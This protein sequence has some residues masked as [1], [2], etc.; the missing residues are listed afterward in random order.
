[1]KKLII[2]LITGTTLMGAAQAQGPY[3][4]AGVHAADRANTF[5]GDNKVKAGVKVFGG[6][7]VTSQFGVEAGYSDFRKD[8][9]SFNIGTVPNR[10]EIE[11]QSY[12]VAGKMTAPL[13][14]KF[15]VFG[16]LGAAHNKA[17]QRGN[18][19]ALTRDTSKNELYAGVGAQF[20]LS[21][22]VALSLEYERFGTKKDFGPKPDVITAA[23]RYNF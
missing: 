6:Y 9:V 7:D 12:Y 18:T 23:A 20:N 15:S 22:R 5:G 4:G 11:G 16:K 17:S 10:A 3:I 13:N 19:P 8:D 1:M 14:D 2:A 21:P